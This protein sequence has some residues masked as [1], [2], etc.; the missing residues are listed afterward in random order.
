[1]GVQ[2]QYYFVT[3]YTGGG[4][5]YGVHLTADVISE[6]ICAKHGPGTLSDDGV[7]LWWDTPD[8]VAEQFYE[9]GL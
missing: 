4:A 6:R 9:V 8:R 2:G 7:D 1:M 3:G 5:V